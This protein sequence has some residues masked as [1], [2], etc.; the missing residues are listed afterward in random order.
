MV[1]HVLQSRQYVGSAT[2]VDHILGFG[3]LQ[4]QVRYEA[5]KAT[6]SAP[7]ASHTADAEAILETAVRTE[8]MA[9][10]SR[11]TY[12]LSCFDGILR[13]NQKLE[14]EYDISMGP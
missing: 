7:L 14:V 3:R 11:A 5:T 13:M 1:T 9:R 12:T 2:V 10:L 6:T 8:V 4:R